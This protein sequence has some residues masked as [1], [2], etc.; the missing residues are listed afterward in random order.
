MARGSPSGDKSTGGQRSND[1]ELVDERETMIAVLDKCIRDCIKSPWKYVERTVGIYS[2]GG[3]GEEMDGE[4]LEGY[5]P[6][7][8]ASPLLMT[9]LEFFEGTVEG[10]LVLPPSAALAIS[11]YLRRL[12]LGISLKQPSIQYVLR[13]TSILDRFLVHDSDGSGAPTHSTEMIQ[14]I[15]REIA[16]LRGALVRMETPA[17]VA[18]LDDEDAVIIFLNQVENLAVGE[19]ALPHLLIHVHELTSC[20]DEEKSSSTAYDLID[21]IRLG[22][23]R[24]T[25]TSALRIIK[26]VEKWY[27]PAISD[28]IL[29]I[30]PNETPIASVLHEYGY[31]RRYVNSQVK[32][33][34]NHSPVVWQSPFHLGLPSCIQGRSG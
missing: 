24:I 22:G 30:D 20:T 8:A 1:E 32:R 27:P 16:M 19:C 29:Q 15:R 5:S 3:T 9:L 31:L 23:R 25:S 17:D 7:S 33:V 14:S 2:E 13:V 34:R 12:L 11:T 10:E 21:W 28:L 4:G 6:S 18:M 26:V